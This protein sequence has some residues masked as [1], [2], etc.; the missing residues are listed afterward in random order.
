MW[1]KSSKSST[2]GSCVE[3]QA[4][5]RGNVK[6]RDSKLGD[7]SPILVFNAQEWDAF[8]EGVRDGEMVSS[9]L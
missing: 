8:V 9:Q 4:D 5:G 6:V 3:I 2:N 1:T 7:T